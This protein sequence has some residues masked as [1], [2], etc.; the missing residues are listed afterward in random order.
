MVNIYKI[1]QAKAEVAKLE[2][3]SQVQIRSIAVRNQ[4]FSLHITL[5]HLG[6]IIDSIA[7]KLAYMD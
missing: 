5:L 2:A 4:P 3:F 1:A 6:M 7:K